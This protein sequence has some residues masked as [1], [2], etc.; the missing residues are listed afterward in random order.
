MTVPF[1][2]CEKG[3]FLFFVLTFLYPFFGRSLFFP[4]FAI[5]LRTMG[6][7]NGFGSSHAI[8]V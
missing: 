6:C 4:T 2:P 5:E 7:E 3:L 1:R 8:K